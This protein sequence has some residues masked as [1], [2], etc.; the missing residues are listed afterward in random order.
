MN[1]WLD[2]IFGGRKFFYALLVVILAFALVLTD[3][4]SADAF[5][6]FV[7]I[8]GGSYVVGNVA[9]KFA[10]PKETNPEVK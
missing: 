3:K 4:I 6:K 8:I 2:N 10:N 7:E 5:L 9:S 1:N